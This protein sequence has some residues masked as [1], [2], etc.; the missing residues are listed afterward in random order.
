MGRLGGGGRGRR[1]GEEWR[2]WEGLKRPLIY[3]YLQSSLSIESKN[4]TA[5]SSSLGL[6]HFVDDPCLLQGVTKQL[7]FW[8]FLCLPT[9]SLAS[10]W[11]LLAVKWPANRSWLCSHCFT[12]RTRKISSNFSHNQARAG[13]NRLE[14]KSFFSQTPCT[15]LTHSLYLSFL[16]TDRI[17]L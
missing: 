6:P 7:F 5:S 11:L 9:I 12:L 17:V 2:G 15:S 3:L 16:R 8:H 10:T 1:E 13:C 4:K 14:K